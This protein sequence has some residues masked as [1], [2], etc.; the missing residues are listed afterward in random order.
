VNIKKP[1]VHV[2]LKPFNTLKEQFASAH[3]ALK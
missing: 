3:I 1:E 2:D